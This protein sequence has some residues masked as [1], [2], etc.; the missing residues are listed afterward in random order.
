MLSLEITGRH[1]RVRLDRVRR[2]FLALLQIV[3][4]DD[5]ERE[6]VEDYLFEIFIDACRMVRGDQTHLFGERKVEIED[7]T[8]RAVASLIVDIT[9]R[10]NVPPRMSAVYFLELLIHSLKEAPKAQTIL[11]ILSWFSLKNAFGV[12]NPGSN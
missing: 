4:V 1:V 8:M 9:I 10:A 2:I 7:T 11:F 3:F 12:L 6:S 5:L